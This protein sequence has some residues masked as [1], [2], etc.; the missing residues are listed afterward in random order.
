V[1]DYCCDKF[2]VMKE[3]V[4]IYR[5]KVF[6]FSGWREIEQSIN[7]D[8]YPKWFREKLRRFLDDAVKCSEEVQRHD[9]EKYYKRFPPLK[10]AEICI[11]ECKTAPMCFENLREWIFHG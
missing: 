7:D 5:K 2:K 6:H 9:L 10:F 1:V 3:Y 8:D 4:Q 11:K